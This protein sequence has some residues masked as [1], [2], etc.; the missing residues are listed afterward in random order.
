MR[1]VLDTNVFIAAALYNGLAREVLDFIFESDLVTLLVSKGIL[2]EL[3]NKLTAK[4][5]WSEEK[6]N[7]YLDDIKI[8]AEI[9]NVLEYLP[10]ISR[11]PQDNKILEC[12]SAGKADLIV[13]IDQDLIELK[14]YKGIAII[15][16]KTFS[17]TFP[18]YFKKSKA[19]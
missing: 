3:H 7:L 19:N 1:I 4:F 16:P 17:W 5:N 15:H 2:H 13:T 12:A 8:M 6:V 9:V 14:R 11:D 10:I 18:E